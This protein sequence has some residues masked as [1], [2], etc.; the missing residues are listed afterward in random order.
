MTFARGRAKNA[1]SEPENLTE[2]LPWLSSR[3]WAGYLISLSLYV[4]VYKPGL[5]LHRVIVRIK[6]VSS[7]EDS[8]GHLALREAAVNISQSHFSSD[9]FGY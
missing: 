8:E 3:P 5:T 2:L 1:G 4:L 7:C 6:Q 9:P